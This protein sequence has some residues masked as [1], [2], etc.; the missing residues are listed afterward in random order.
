MSKYPVATV[1][2]PS[3]G[4][5][6]RLPVLLA[7]LSRQDISNFEVIVVL[8][9]DT[10]GSE[11]F[12][13]RSAL[14]APF[15]LRWIVF[16][17]NRGRSAAL[18]AGFA[19]AEGLI[20]IRSD[21]DLEPGANFVSGHVKRH[22]GGR[23]GVIGLTT[24]RFPPTPYARIYGSKADELHRAEAVIAPPHTH[25]RHWSANV[26]I[27][28]EVHEFLGGYDE[29][30]RTYGWE[31]VDYGYRLH[32]AGVPI[33][34]APELLTLH[35]A[36]STTTAIRSM[37]ALH[38]GAARDI[39]LDIHGPEVLPKP[40]GNSSLW[41]RLVW[42]ASALATE[43]SISGWAAAVDQV[44]DALP[45]SAAEKLI[46]L[47]VESAALAGIRYPRRARSNF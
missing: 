2:V 10:D 19:E 18:N 46:A 5:A 17:E 9:G 36:A 31:D 30:Y 13:Q 16:A 7:A 35:H 45:R 32:R 41:G 8:D 20:L 14:V 24:N 44:A 23:V 40:N 26:S 27:P 25:W 39:F 42:I 47:S 28:R 22:Q 21:D 3:R 29:R 38:S 1:V 15:A 37:R 43:R 4:G 6:K 11:G 33:V 12:L 34:I